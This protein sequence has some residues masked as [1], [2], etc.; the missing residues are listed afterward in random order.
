[1][2]IHSEK[3]E[4]LS[5]VRLHGLARSDKHAPA[6][7]FPSRIE[8]HTLRTFTI[9]GPLLHG[10]KLRFCSRNRVTMKTIAI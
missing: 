10:K 1:M 5:A 2:G 4:S 3:S 7:T 6:S 8:L 9:S